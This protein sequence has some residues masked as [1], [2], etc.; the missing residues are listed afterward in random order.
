[1]TFVADAVWRLGLAWSD[2]SALRASWSTARPFGHL[3]LDDVVDEARLRGMLSALDE[4]PIE[5]GTAEIYAFEASKPEPATDALRALRES[6]AATFGPPLARI[7]GKT[8]RRADMR[9]YAYREGHHLLPHTDHQE[10]VG[11]ALAYAYYLPS[12]EPPVGG[13]LELFT[14]RVEHGALV[15]T[16]PGPVIE[17]RANRLVVF[18]VGDLSLHQVREVTSGVR[19]SLSGWFYP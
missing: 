14:C 17:P 10:E 16:L 9:L 5:Q 2:E 7:T 8:L 1:M 15:E 11:R 3:V 19:L 13:E 18:D 4:E 6:F 12:P